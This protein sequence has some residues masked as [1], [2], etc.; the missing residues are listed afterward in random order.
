MLLALQQ[1]DVGDKA[2]RN[3][4][5]KKVSAE[6]EYF[7][8]VW[9]HLKGV[10]GKTRFYGNPSG[11]VTPKFLSTWP[12]KA[13]FAQQRGDLS[14]LIIPEQRYHNKVREWLAAGES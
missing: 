4:G 10:Y 6:L 3:A 14:F 9:D 11:F 12:D 2:K 8:K 13:D 5:E 1:S 7:D